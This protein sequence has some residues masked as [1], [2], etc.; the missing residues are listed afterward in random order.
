MRSSVDS[1]LESLIAQDVQEE[2]VHANGFVTVQPMPVEVHGPNA[3]KTL[4]LRRIE[5]VLE[6][7]DMDEHVTKELQKVFDAY[8][9]A[10][11]LIQLH[12]AL[13][14]YRYPLSN[15]LFCSDTRISS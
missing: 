14:R 13:F 1:M 7:T 5:K 2:G 11:V 10:Y 4:P 9:E 6:D 12:I 8:N 3:R 15:A